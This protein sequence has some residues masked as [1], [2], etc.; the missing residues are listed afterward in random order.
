MHEKY[1]EDGSTLIVGDDE[2]YYLGM[3]NLKMD[4]FLV[5]KT[6]LLE[7]LGKI[8][9]LTWNVIVHKKSL[10]KKFAVNYLLV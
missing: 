5:Q 3:L 1:S 7:T 4:S 2:K 9:K 8:I 6:A 10:Y